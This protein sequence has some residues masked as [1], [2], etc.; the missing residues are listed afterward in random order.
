MLADITNLIIGGGLTMV[1][2]MFS[3]YATDSIHTRLVYK[4]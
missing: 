4:F 2:Y 1:A 3:K